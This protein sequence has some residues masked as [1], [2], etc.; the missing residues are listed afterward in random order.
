MMPTIEALAEVSCTRVNKEIKIFKS[1]PKESDR[2]KLTFFILNRSKK[3]R[4]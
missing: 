2:R 1:A 4:V 3:R